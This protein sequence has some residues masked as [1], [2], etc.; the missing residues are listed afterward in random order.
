MVI[1]KIKVPFVMPHLDFSKGARFIPQVPRVGFVPQFF[2]KGG[3]FKMGSVGF[4]EPISAQS[5]AA[6]ESLRSKDIIGFKLVQAEAQRYK[7]GMTKVN[8]SDMRMLF[9]ME[10][11]GFVEKPSSINPSR[12]TSFNFAK[13]MNRKG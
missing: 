11:G 8:P 5:F 13:F 6:R 3:G 4:K 9:N 10:R 7:S 12:L 1:P 2:M